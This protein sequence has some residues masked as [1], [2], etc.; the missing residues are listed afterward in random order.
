MP[1]PKPQNPV[2]SSPKEQ[3]VL[4]KSQIQC[5]GDQY[6]MISTHLCIYMHIYTQ[7]WTHPH[8]HTHNQVHTPHTSTHTNPHPQKYSHPCTHINICTRVLTHTYIHDNTHAYTIQICTTES[9]E[10]EKK[11]RKRGIGGRGREETN[12]ARDWCQEKVNVA[13]HW[14]LQD[15][16]WTSR[17][18]DSD[19][20]WVSCLSPSHS[21]E[22]DKGVELPSFFTE[23]QS[24]KLSFMEKNNHP[25]PLKLPVIVWG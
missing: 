21:V 17:P 8:T 22:S 13:L 4:T 5:A 18:S 3:T 11:K 25:S 10:F 24:P 20:Q 7:S 1:G 19:T 6:Q 2:A 15:T 12:T 16:R 14:L 23:R 9:G